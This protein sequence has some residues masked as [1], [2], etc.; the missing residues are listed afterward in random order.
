MIDIILLDILTVS[1][2]LYTFA[3]KPHFQV[4][5]HTFFQLMS[6]YP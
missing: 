4:N 6:L 5:R 1:L 3:Q 2:K